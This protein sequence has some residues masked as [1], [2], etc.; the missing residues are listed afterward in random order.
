[1][2]HYALLGEKLG[3]SYSVPIHE[4]IFQ[5]TGWAA[6]YRLIEIPRGELSTRMAVLRQ[7]LDGCNV[8]IPYKQEIM[9]LLD[10][11][12]PFARQVGAVNTVQFA[13]GRACGYNTDVEGFRAMLE[14]QGI[15]PAGKPAYVM[16]TGGA[17]RAAV[18]ALHDMGAAQ[19]LLVS[20]HPAGEEISYDRL[21]EV[22]T[23]VLVNC[24][25]AGM[26][27]HEEGC[28]LTAAQL[29]AVL[30]RL[31]GVADMIYHPAETVLTR[32]AKAA[33]VNACTGLYM[34][35]H[36]AVAAEEIWQGRTLGR[37]LTDELMKEL[38]LV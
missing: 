7:E 8:T 35:I 20:R 5:R 10:E 4:A 31:T 16:G 25:P 37:E 33:G 30:P 6:E 21:A 17:S 23:G 24:T 36:Q 14:Q 29:A 3:H 38:Q 9:P 11:I 34:L 32:A 15:D 18:T 22:G 12:S 19:V 1:M 26:Y 13:A 27:P 28:P 2:R